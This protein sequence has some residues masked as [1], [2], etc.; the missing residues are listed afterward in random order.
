[1]KADAER[2]LKKMETEISSVITQFSKEL[3]Q[4]KETI[5]SNLRAIQRMRARDHADNDTRHIRN[6][7]SIAKNFAMLDDHAQHFESIGTVTTMLVENL[8]MQMESELCDL[9]DRKLV[10]LYGFN[11]PGA[12]LQKVDVVGASEQVKNNKVVTKQG[13]PE[14]KI[15]EKT[16]LE[17]TTG[18]GTEV[19][20][21]K[22]SALNST[23]METKTKVE[24]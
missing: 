20:F 23:F 12:D 11:R 14:K 1:M 9:M 19:T 24:S 10:S 8:S 4:A 13:K 7:E 5:E 21:P 3:D 16:G 18:S 2:F 6:E 17:E 15:H 22:I